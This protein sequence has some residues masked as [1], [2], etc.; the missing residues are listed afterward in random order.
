MSHIWFFIP[1]TKENKADG[2]NNP[3]NKLTANSKT[4]ET[5]GKTNAP[6][7]I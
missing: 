3:M 5:V 1:N 2:N 4:S 7:V 6:A